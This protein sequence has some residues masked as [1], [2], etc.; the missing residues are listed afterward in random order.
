MLAEILLTLKSLA[1]LAGLL[2][3]LISEVK[4]LRLATEQRNLDQL[5]SDINEKIELLKNAKTDDD[6]KRA[7]LDIANRMQK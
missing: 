2:Q 1:A 3:D 5:K 7:L 4:S 6:R